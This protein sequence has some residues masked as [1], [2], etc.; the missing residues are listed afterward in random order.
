MQ[1]KRKKKIKILQSFLNVSP[2]LCTKY[3]LQR[4]FTERDKSKSYK[5]NFPNEKNGI[6]K[7]K[8]ERDK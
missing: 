5:S 6:R 1:I 7:F 2:Q 3:H 4:D 8:I